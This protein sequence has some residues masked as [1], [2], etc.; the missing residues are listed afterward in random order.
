VQRTLPVHD[1]GVLLER[2]A[3]HAVAPGVRLLVEVP[4]RA[5]EDAADERLHTGLV[6]R[7]GGAD[8]LVVGDPQPR[9]HGL[10]ADGH[11]VGERLRVHPRRGRGLLHLLAVLV[12]A[13]E[14][15]HVV[16]GLPLVAGDHVGPDL[17]QGV[18]QMRVAVGVVDGG[19]EEETG[20]AQ[21]GSGRGG[22]SSVVARRCCVP[23][24]PSRRL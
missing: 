23:V 4:R 2:L 14:Q 17:L 1:V 3:P 20:H 9:P 11:L 19:G 8:E 15:V 18:P 16:P 12:H 13:D 6:V 7:V 24:P 21:D 5:L 22:G 10:E